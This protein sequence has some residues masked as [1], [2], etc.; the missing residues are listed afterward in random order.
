MFFLKGKIFSIN[1]DMTTVISN[2]IDNIILNNDM[3]QN[4]LRSKYNVYVCEQ[5]RVATTQMLSC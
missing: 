2:L 5:L 4:K 1:Y 3:S